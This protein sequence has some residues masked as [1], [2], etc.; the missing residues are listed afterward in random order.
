MAAPAAV[1]LVVGQ[2][3]SF[4]GSHNYAA[5][6]DWSSWKL[7]DPPDVPSSSLDQ[8]NAVSCKSSDYC[9]ATGHFLGGTTSGGQPESLVWDG[10]TWALKT[11]PVPSQA[12]N[13]W[14]YGVSCPSTSFCFAVGDYTIASP[15]QP[16][17]A[18]TWDG[19]AWAVRPSQSINQS[20]ALASTSCV[21][22]TTCEAVG[23]S[24]SPKLAFSSLGGSWSGKSF[25]L[26]ATPDSGPKLTGS[27]LRGV[28][29]LPVTFCMAVGNMSAVWNGTAW[30]MASFPQASPILSVAY[31]LSC[32]SK[33]SCAAVGSYENLSKG[34]L[35]LIV[36]WNG[37]SWQQQAGANP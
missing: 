26:R 15:H 30:S 18:E 21:S 24:L 16:T 17:L 29:C 27:D 9:V 20:N 6:W 2:W 5:L 34:G 36:N 22:A 23:N 35:T 3:G 13:A 19:T 32:T 10:S 1:C 12:T 31:A 14:L 33:S 8:L 7:L 25:T 4:A 28:S 37:T 11:V